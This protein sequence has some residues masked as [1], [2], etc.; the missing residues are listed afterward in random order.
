MFCQQDRAILCR[1]CDVPIHKA[2]EHTEKHNRFLLTGVKLS[3]TS[4]LYSPSSSSSSS[5]PSQAEAAIAT[6]TH[7]NV[8]DVVP[9]F[10]SNNRA[11][12]PA[13]SVNP[14][15]SKTIAKPTTSAFVDTATAA[16]DNQKS[17]NNNVQ[18]MNGGDNSNSPPTSS[19]AEYLIEMLP[20]WHVEDFLDSSSP[21][22]F[23]KV[24]NDPFIFTIQELPF[25]TLVCN[26]KQKSFPISTHDTVFFPVPD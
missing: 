2:N 1:E 16:A 21:L 5:W 20:G 18:M 8:Y 15:V 26:K 11:N 25:F 12:N 10:N 19:I 17:I 6:T 14:T 9:N 22:G 3:A 23:C 4:A 24:C 7:T 13:V